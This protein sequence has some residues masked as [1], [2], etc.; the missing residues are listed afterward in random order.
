MIEILK[1]LSIFWYRFKIQA[2]DEI[3]LPAF[4][5]SAFRGGFGH[6][7]RKCVCIQK[8]SNCLRCILNERCAYTYLFE[9]FALREAGIFKN[10]DEIPRPFVIE[11]PSGTKTRYF[12][13]ETMEFNLILFGKA[14]EFFPYVVFAFF[15]FG[16]AGIGRNRG[17]FKIKEVRDY[18]NRVVFDGDRLQNY[19]TRIYLD[20]YSRFRRKISLLFFT[21]ARI[22]YRGHY[23]NKPE[24]HIIIKALLR[25]ISTILTFYH[26]IEPE[27]DYKNLNS[28][29]KKIRIKKED[30]KWVDL[31][32]YSKRQNSEM[33]LGGFMG[34]ITYEGEIKPFLPLL[35][36][37]QYTHIGKN[38]TFG[39]GGYRIVKD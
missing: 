2:L 27:F 38:C 14:K 11:P 24:F 4:K 32:R 16:R 36:S 25:R 17:R 10:R 7:L 33:K 15:N 3:I 20:F 12:P 30:I 21:P 5:G 6:H 28:E 39:L 23:V 29:A 34:Q 19:D 13:G 31:K 37:G 9:S 35:I 26:N 1:K 18:L 22:K 8:Q